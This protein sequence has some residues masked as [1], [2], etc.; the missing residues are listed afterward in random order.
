MTALGPR[1]VLA[2]PR[3]LLA[4]HGR[5]VAAGHR[6]RGDPRARSATVTASTVAGGQGEL[7]GRILRIGSFGAIEAGDIVRGLAAL[8]VELLGAGHV[9]ELGAGVGA[10][11]RAHALMRVLVTETIAAA[12]IDRLREA[13][14]VDVVDG[15]RARRPAGADRR[16]RRAR[17][18]LRH[19]R[20]RRADRGR[21]AAARDRPGRHRRRQRRRRGGH[22][23]RH[24]GLQRAAVER[25]VGGRARDRADAGAG[26]QHPA[27]RT[28]RWSPG[29]GSAAAS[30]A[31][32]W[33]TRRS[34]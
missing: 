22:G 33:P 30:P 20:R 27:G 14:E 4:G 11:S 34:P 8:E 6:R 10:F 5:A 19:A 16:L 31:S 3:R 24:P 12:G 15:P 1:A 25:A 26:A 17:R 13:A 7:E 32:S 29:A 21:H 28:R 9:I 2:R 23:A 18:P